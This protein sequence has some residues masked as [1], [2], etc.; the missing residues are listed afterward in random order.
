ML[1]K[2][3]FLIAVL[4]TN[5]VAGT[6][7]AT[8]STHAAAGHAETALTPTALVTESSARFLIGLL[9]DDDNLY[10]VVQG[11]FDPARMRRKTQVVKTSKDG[12]KRQVLFNDAETA[13]GGVIPTFTAQ[14]TANVYVFRTRA[15]TAQE[16]S[17]RF[18][19]DLLA[20]PKAG[21]S[22]EGNPV[23][24]SAVV[25]DGDT[26]RG[27]ASSGGS[28]YWVTNRTLN[29]I[30]PSTRRVTKLADVAAKGLAVDNAGIYVAVAGDDF[31]GDQL[32]KFSLTGDTN[33]LLAPNQPNV[34]NLQ[35]V[36]D[37]LYY[38]SS[39]SKADFTFETTIRRT[40]TTSTDEGVTVVAP[41]A[42]FNGGYAVDATNTNVYL[43]DGEPG[44]AQTPAIRVVASGG[45]DVTTLFSGDRALAAS[46][47]VD[48]SKVYWGGEQRTAATEDLSLLALDRPD[49]AE[50]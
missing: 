38:V 5:I 25:A 29:R 21:L 26:P 19:T 27:I 40:S 50:K 15:A 44:G 49:R 17:G 16:E 10:Y 28:V 24:A 3:R 8:Q 32:R 18:A 41:I 48:D 31:N 33:S 35:V 34:S 2:R 4:L 39:R 6:A 11:G 42:N 9:T 20:I 46:I 1:T 36:G 23:L 12:N 30:D 7:C 43:A 22:D 45:G 13:S 47:V 37:F 14:D